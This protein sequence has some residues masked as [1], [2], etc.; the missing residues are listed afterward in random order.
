[1][2]YYNKELTYNIELL[3]N[4]DETILL[5]EFK[6]ADIEI[7][8]ILLLFLEPK[9]AADILSNFDIS[10]QVRILLFIGGFIQISQE[11]LLFL[12]NL[13]GGTDNYYTIEHC[14]NYKKIGGQDELIEI[15]NLL[16]DKDKLVDLIYQVDKKLYIEVVPHLL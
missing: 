4:I 15:L 3:N 6:N 13:V 12:N 10:L 16:K 8:S 5:D 11:S 9:K 7:I 1:M 14:I 2:L